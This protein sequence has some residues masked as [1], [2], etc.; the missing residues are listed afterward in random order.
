LSAYDL[1]LKGKF[2]LRKG[3]K[4]NILQAREIFE[5]ALELDANHAQA[6]VQLA[7]TYISEAQSDWASAPE[8]AAERALD[9]ARKAVD[10]DDRDSDAHLV[11]AWA[12]FRVKS[13]F[14]LAKSELE[15]AMLL[16][17]NEYYN[18]CFKSW[19]LTCSGDPSG[20]ISCGNEALR[21]NPFV[22]DGCL[23][24]IGFADYLA[25]SYE[26]AI[27]ILVRITHPPV[28]VV[29]CI[30]ACHAQLGRHEQAHAAAG[31]FL[32]RAKSELAIFPGGDTE[33]WRAY[34]L[35]RMPFKEEALLTNLLDGLQKAGLPV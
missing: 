35:R 21:R 5:R 13:N 28:E 26:Q 30:A 4:D 31:E 22:H 8:R 7:Y 12:Y 11:L 24:S 23:Y 15:K 19:F 16:N 29:A 9:L 10:L 2:V 25:G 6:Y 27:S 34:W 3:T 1:V 14:D 32:D 17:P 33:T 20:G 18:Y